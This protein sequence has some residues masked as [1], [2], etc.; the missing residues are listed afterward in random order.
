MFTSSTFNNPNYSGFTVGTVVDTNDP[1]QTGRVRVLV[2]SYGDRPDMSTENLPWAVCVSPLGGTVNNEKIKRGTEEAS[3]NGPV[4]YGFWNIPKIGTTVVVTCIDG[5]PMSRL[6]IGSL[7][8][9]RLSHTLPHGRFIF[10]DGEPDGP[11]DSYEQPIQP[12]YD[13]QTNAFGSRTGNYE[14]R[15]RGADYSVSATSGDFYITDGINSTP[16][17]KDHKF[18]SADGKTVNIRQGYGLSQI[19]PTLASSTTKENFD[20]QVYSWTSPGFHSISMDDRKENCRVKIRTTSGHQIILD[21]TNER[22]YI[23]TSNGNSWIEFDE[24][25][26][27]DIYSATKVNVRTEGDI[28]FTANKSIRMYADEAIH[29]FTKQVR[30]QTIEDLHIKAGT[31]VKVH[32]ASDMNLQTDTNL[33][34]NV[35]TEGM[36]KT[37]GTLHLF[38]GGNILGKGSQVQF[39]GSPP[40]EAAVAGEE[41]AKWTNRLPSHEPYARTTTKTDYSHEPK[42]S[43]DDPSIGSEDKTRG[44]YWRR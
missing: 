36:I 35:G 27:I 38:A 32:S 11:L 30:I 4:A 5:H 28:N 17:D 6:W 10:G 8:T 21:D 34:I 29:M 23:N 42:Y 26:N 9:E 25:G 31:Y 40:S 19:E 20:S 18:T 24:D 37:G 2:P 16:D 7:H 13:N 3:S 22:I 14:W 1:Q 12:L 41:P 43:Y 15:T 44:K 33:N 39:N